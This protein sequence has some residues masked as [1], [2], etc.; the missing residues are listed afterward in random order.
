M[1]SGLQYRVLTSGNECTPMVDEY[2]RSTVH[3][4]GSLIDGTEINSSDTWQAIPSWKEVLTLMRQGDKWDVSIPANLAYGD[5][6]DGRAIPPGAVLR[7]E[8]ELV[9]GRLMSFPEKDENLKTAATNEGKHGDQNAPAKPTETIADPGPMS[10]TPQDLSESSTLRVVHPSLA[11]SFDGRWANEDQASG[12]ITVIQDDIISWNTG[13]TSKIEF[14]EP[15]RFRTHFNSAVYEA[16]LC[17]D[18]RLRWDSGRV[19][20]REASLDPRDLKPATVE[21][22]VAKLEAKISEAKSS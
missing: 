16:E 12:A 19:W 13:A 22:L 3:F 5:K 9:S 11:H 15:K 21:Q 4:R 18:G 20:I 2:T 8:I 10:A 14:L 7:L 17:A 1:P 6:G